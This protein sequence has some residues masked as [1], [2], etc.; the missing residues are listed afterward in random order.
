MNKTLIFL[1]ISCGIV[2]F[3]VIVINT[4]P[5]IKLNIG[6]SDENC[7]IYADL[8]EYNDDEKIN[9]NKDEREKTVKSFKKA[10]N[11]CNRDK[12]IYG[13]EYASVVLDVVLGF[14]CALLSLLHYFE[15]GKSFQKY[16]GLIGCISGIICFIITFVYFVYSTYIFNNDSPAMNLSTNSGMSYGGLLILDGDGALAKLDGNEYK[17]IEDYDEDKIDKLYAKYKDLG[18]KQYQYNKDSIDGDSKFNKCNIDGS[19]FDNLVG[20]KCKIVNDNSKM[21]EG[22]ACDFLYKHYDDFSNKYTFDL[23]ITSIIFDALVLV[24]TLGLII[25]GFLLFKDSNGGH[26]PI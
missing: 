7:K 8:Q 18:K 24:L 26:T 12:A 2:I 10:K 11:K 25:F 1:C 19:N 14:I 13:L 22:K 6:E 20:S 5:V 4:G 23:W 21:Y 3:T 15:V 16:T 9:Q 17:C